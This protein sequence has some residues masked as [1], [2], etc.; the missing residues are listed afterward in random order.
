[1]LVGGTAPARQPTPAQCLQDAK[2][3]AMPNQVDAS[4]FTVGSAY[5]MITDQT[6]LVWFTVTDNHKGSY[7]VAA[8]LWTQN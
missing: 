1:M 3:H 8:T 4:A 6:N 5:C 7:T 2:T